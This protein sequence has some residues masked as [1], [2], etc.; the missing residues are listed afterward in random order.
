MVNTTATQAPLFSQKTNEIPSRLFLINTSFRDVELHNYITS[1]YGQAQP[2]IQP[3]KSLKQ[4]AIYTNQ[5][6]LLNYCEGYSAFTMSMS[7]DL[8]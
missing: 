8:Y 3:P 1:Q 6:Q 2:H 7:S 5:N 4:S